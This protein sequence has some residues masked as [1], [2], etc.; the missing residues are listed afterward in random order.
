VNSENRKKSCLTRVPYAAVTGLMACLASS[1]A[2]SSGGHWLVDDAAV[3]PPNTMGV[4]AWYEHF[5]D[6]LDAMTVQPAY[7]FSNGMEL[8]GV[9]AS[10]SAGNDREQ[11]FGLELK[12]AWLDFEAGDDFG[13]G[14][15]Y[16]TQHDDSGSRQEHYFYIP[17]TLPLRE[18]KWLLHLNAGW[19]GDRSGGGTDHSFFYGI[20]SQLAL[21]DNLG[22]I[23]EGMAS[24]EDDTYLQTGLRFDLGRTDGLLDLSYGWNIDNSDDDWFTL[25]FGWEF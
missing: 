21:G 2:L 8:S 19:L 1:P 7:G 25:G 5:G 18:D 4:E 22:W 13:I 3:L 12:Q 16:G 6:S 15:V 14:W 23:L 11:F 24:S 17:M 9:L 20:G 10:S